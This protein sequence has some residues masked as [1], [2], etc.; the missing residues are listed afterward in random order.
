MRNIIKLSILLLK[1][2][3]KFIMLSIF[4]LLIL[5]NG[6]SQCNP[7]IF[8]SDITVNTTWDL[9]YTGGTGSMICAGMVHVNPGITLTITGITVNFNTGSGITADIGG[10]LNISFSNLQANMGAGA[11][12][13]IGLIAEG[14]PIANQTALNQGKIT[15]TTVNI[16]EACT[17]ITARNGGIVN[18]TDCYIYR[19]IT[20]G[21]LMENYLSPTKIDDQSTFVRCSIIRLNTNVMQNVFLDNVYGVKF[22]ACDFLNNAA[23]GITFPTGI[24]AKNATFSLEAEGPC[25]IN[26]NTNCQTCQGKGNSFKRFG[27]AIFIFD[28]AVNTTVLNKS[29][30]ISDVLFDQNYTSV[31]NNLSHSNGQSYRLVIKNC[32]FT[33]TNFGYNEVDIFSLE[34]NFNLEIM[35]NIFSTNNESIRNIWVLNNSYNGVNYSIARNS[36]INGFKNNSLYQAIGIELE[37]FKVLESL[38]IKCNQFL[39]PY[40]NDIYLDVAVSQL[41]YPIVSSQDNTFNS[42]SDFNIYSKHNLDYYFSTVNP[43]FNPVLRTPNV[44]RIWTLPPNDC[45]INCVETSG[46]SGDDQLPNLL[47]QRAIKSASYFLTEPLLTL[48]IANIDNFKQYFLN[49]YGWDVD[50]ILRVNLFDSKA[51]IFATQIPEK[52][53]YYYKIEDAEGNIIQ[54]GKIIKQ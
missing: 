30:L 13:W 36:F 45:I 7:P 15:L 40:E 23:G 37:D 38:T 44:N 8:T 43:D 29:I 21:I 20:Q 1:Q 49:V 34:S 52:G 28:N 48:D 31:L 9:A 16:T 41:S 46:G 3:R 18:A 25:I 53:I 24:L 14:N 22:I 10:H 12:D 2:S 33:S 26:L 11:T 4:I 51:R 6:F 54:T 42:L 19:F 50:P 35:D 39:L 17:A 47:A 27:R 32:T 5:K